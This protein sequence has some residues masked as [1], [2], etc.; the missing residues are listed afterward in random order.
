MVYEAQPGAVVAPAAVPPKC[1]PFVH[2]LV[3]RA[4]NCIGLNEIQKQEMGVMPKP[5]PDPTIQAVVKG[6]VVNGQPV[7]EVKLY[8]TNGF[9]IWRAVTGTNEF[10]YFDRSAS[11]TYTDESPLPPGLL[12]VQYDYKVRLIGPDN[13]PVTGFSDVVT[14]TKTA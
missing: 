13:V 9:E 7:S 11:N 14:L 8:G 12:A 6:E 2:N 1:K 10:I 3:L 4:R 5:K